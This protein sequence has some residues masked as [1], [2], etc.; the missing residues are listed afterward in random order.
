MIFC[1]LETG[2]KL[3]PSSRTLGTSLLVAGCLTVA[4]S[5]G[6]DAYV[7]LLVFFLDLIRGV[8]DFSSGSA[9]RTRTRRRV[10][11]AFTRYYS[12]FIAYLTNAQVIIRLLFLRTTHRVFHS[13]IRIISGLCL[14]YYTADALRRYE[15]YH[16]LL[17]CSK[18]RNFL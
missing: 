10:Q 13:K 9:S 14:Y 5:I 11:V 2:N 4:S 17:E 8:L 15:Q 18:T 1:T 3:R 7:L 12:V 16:S 6:E